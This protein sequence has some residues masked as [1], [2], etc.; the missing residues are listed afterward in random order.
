MRLKTCRVKNDKG[1]TRE[2]MTEREKEMSKKEKERGGDYVGTALIRFQV[3]TKQNSLC[4][5]ISGSFSRRWHLQCR[6]IPVQRLVRM[7]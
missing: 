4:T 7:F 2:I 6:L 3:Y 1:I 5:R